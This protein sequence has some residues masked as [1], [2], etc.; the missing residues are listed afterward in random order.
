MGD[1]RARERRYHAQGAMR[2]VQSQDRLLPL[3]FVLLSIGPA[4]ADGD[5]PTADAA[6][7]TAAAWGAQT[8]I[9]IDSSFYMVDR[10]LY[11]E[12]INT[13]KPPHPAWTWDASVQ[14]GALCSAARRQ[15]Q[16]YLPRVKAYAAA[17]RAYR[18]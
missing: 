2:A 5:R 6:R 8:L 11:A 4:T 9:Q 13:G 17:L 18:T 15:P 1:F 3:L 7:P 10:A 16:T 12:Q 14:L